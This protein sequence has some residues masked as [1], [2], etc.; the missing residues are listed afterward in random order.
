MNPTLD[1]L[2]AHRS[3]RAFRPDP[4]PDAHL[5][6]AVERAQ[7]AATSSHVQAY[8]LLDVT[9]PA[10]REALVEL[11]GGQSGNQIF[12]FAFCS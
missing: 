2:A 1:L 7:C 5:R 10:E 6:L 8:S 3:I 4:V 12:T 9:D 11:T